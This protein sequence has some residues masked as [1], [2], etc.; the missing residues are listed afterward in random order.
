MEAKV[1]KTFAFPG[2]SFQGSLTISDDEYQAVV[3][4][5]ELAAG[6]AGRLTTRTSD[7]VGVV[8]MTTGHGFTTSQVV[9]LYWVGGMRLG[10]VLGTVGAPTADTAVPIASGGA[11]DVLPADETDVVMS[12]RTIITLPLDGDALKLMAFLAGG[13]AGLNFLDDL[14]ASLDTQELADAN[15]PYDWALGS[16]TNPLA[17]ET[18]GS[19][20]AS[21]GAAAATTLQYGL[22]HDAV[23]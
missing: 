12:A 16:G 21:S 20:T 13:R 10:V 5:P 15:S 8:T 22:L 1:T 2:M 14:D 3:G 4:N 18:L 23:A 11:G 6:K 9:D 17:G 19:I 7:S